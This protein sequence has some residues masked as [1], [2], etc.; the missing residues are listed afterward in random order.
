MVHSYP[1]HARMMYFLEDYI[2]NPT[3]QQKIREALEEGPVATPGVYRSQRYMLMLSDDER[4]RLVTELADLFSE[5]GVLPNQEPNDT[6]CFIEE[7]IGRF[8]PR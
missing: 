1:I 5:I 4:D 7:I 8:A 6:G 2:L 3:V